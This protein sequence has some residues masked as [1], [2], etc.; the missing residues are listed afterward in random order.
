MC[1]VNWPW[2][3]EGIFSWWWSSFGNRK[4]YCNFDKSYSV[5]TETT[6]SLKFFGP[7]RSVGNWESFEAKFIHNANWFHGI[8]K[9]WCFRVSN[10][11][12]KLS[13]IRNADMTLESQSELFK[14]LKY[15]FFWQYGDVLIHPDPEYSHA[16]TQTTPREV[17]IQP[18]LFLSYNPTHRFSLLAKL[19][20]VL[21]GKT[22]RNYAVLPGG[23][24][25]PSYYTPKCIAVQRTSWPKVTMKIVQHLNVI[26]TDSEM[27]TNLLIQMSYAISLIHSIFYLLG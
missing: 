2:A 7:G 10:L 16:D 23:G 3:N 4:G 1:F 11:L 14:S 17:H 13:V 19:N 27:E 15:R 20:Y 6:D 18:D 8:P 25:E 24:P 22:T 26:Y 21:H 9:V 12:I 5:R